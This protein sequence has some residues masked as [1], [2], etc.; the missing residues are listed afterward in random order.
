M[1][2]NNFILS[3]VYIEYIIGIILFPMK[4][5]FVL[6]NEYQMLTIGLM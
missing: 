4:V 6:I 1:N 3:L 2:L 5:N